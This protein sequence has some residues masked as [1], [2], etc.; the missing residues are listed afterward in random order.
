VEGFDSILP[1]EFFRALSTV[2]VRPGTIVVVLEYLYCI[3]YGYVWCQTWSPS[4]LPTQFY[5][6]VAVVKQRPVHHDIARI[7]R[8]KLGNQ[9]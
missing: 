8:P 4:A 2:G 3:K 7:R 9:K 6:K 5:K 1:C